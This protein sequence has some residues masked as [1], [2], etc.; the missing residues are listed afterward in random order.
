MRNLLVTGGAGF[1][2]ANFVHHMLKTDRSI[3]LINLDLLTYAGSLDKL[4]GIEASERYRFIQGDICDRSLVEQ[5]FRQENIDTVIHFAAESHV[6]RSISGPDDFIQ[7]NIVGTFILLDVARKIWLEEKGWNQEKCRF[8]QISTDEIY[9]SLTLDDPPFTERSAYKPNSPYSAAKASA[10]HCVRA[11]MKTYGL[12]VSM[13]S[14]SNNYGP[15]QDREK[16]IPT[17]IRSCLNE[18]TIPVYGD[19]R[20]VRDWLFVTDH[21]AA[22]ECVVYDG[23]VGEMYN[24][25]GDE[26]WANIDLVRLICKIMDHK[27]PRQGEKKHQDLIGFVK[28]RPGHDFR[29][30]IDSSKLKRALNWSPKVTFEEGLKKTIQWYLDHQQT[31]FN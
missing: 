2:G 4:V 23:E 1:I 21:C 5:I 20:N 11:Y 27:R 12:P 19:G 31:V 26:E 16:L 14:C 29:Y 13:T 7:T 18:T 9:G 30:A 24:V 8:H 3:R 6:D 28:D 10:D 15:F 22:I 25:G 17:V